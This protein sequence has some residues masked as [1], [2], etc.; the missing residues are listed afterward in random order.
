MRALA[1]RLAT[2]GIVGDAGAARTK[3]A[4]WV[5]GLRQALDEAW[6]ARRVLPE[7]PTNVSSP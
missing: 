5:G 2:G 1:F 6:K 3:N 4:V 7:P